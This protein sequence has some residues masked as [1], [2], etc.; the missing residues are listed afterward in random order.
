MLNKQ[1][2][3]P[4]L[5]LLKNPSLVCLLHLSSDAPRSA[6]LEW[7]G[8]WCPPGQGK[9]LLC[10]PHLAEHESGSPQKHMGHTPGYQ[11][12]TECLVGAQPL[13]SMATMGAIGVGRPQHPVTAL[14]EPPHC[15]KLQSWRKRHCVLSGGDHKPE[16]RSGEEAEKSSGC[17]IC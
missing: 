13:V 1:D 12:E 7:T 14:S 4:T 5:G 10:P 17:V 3:L 6:A 11:D 9:G 15:Q 8:S 16:T 2:F